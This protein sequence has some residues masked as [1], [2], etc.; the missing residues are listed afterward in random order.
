MRSAEHDVVARAKRLAYEL[1]GA[2][3]HRRKYTG[4]PYTNHLNAVA[5]M[6]AGAGGTD[7]MVAAAW[8]HD[9]IEDAGATPL[10]IAES[11]GRIV[12][13]LV[14]EMTDVSRPADGNRAS[15]K[16]IDRH[17]LAHASPEAKTIKL[18]DLL[19]NADSI[20]RYDER[21]ARTYIAEMDL[22]LDQA[23]GKGDRKLWQR[24]KEVT[25]VFLATR[26]EVTQ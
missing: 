4:E 7:E 10:S 23:L 25:R 11:C 19:D 15:R 14:V 9:S 13:D 16:A 8:L 5:T 20:V 6:V 1:H 22:L 3:D 17:H 18:A 2:I 21:F 12:A 24:A 26:N